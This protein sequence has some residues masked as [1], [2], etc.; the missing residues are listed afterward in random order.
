MNRSRLE[1]PAALTDMLLYRINRLRAVGGGIVLRYCEGQFGITRREWVM[2]ALLS[3]A[4]SATPSELAARAELNKPATSKA[5]TS[6]ARK[7][8]VMRDPRRG[9][10][11]YVQLRLTDK[12]RELYGRILPLVAQVNREL[13]AGLTAQETALLDAILDRL[14]QQADR[15]AQQLEHLPRADRRR[16]GTRRLPAEGAAQPAD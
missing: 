13:M 9:D 4:P 14:E 16:G 5:I 2:L 6:L 7:G 3:I 12:G 11:R 8:L 15:M 10:R 1:Q